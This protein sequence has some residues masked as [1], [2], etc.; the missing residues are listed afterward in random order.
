MSR[1]ALIVF[2]GCDSS[3]KT[4]QCQKLVTALNSE[5]IAAKL[6]AFPDRTTSTGQIINK[7]LK[8]E[9]DLED[10]AIHL[11][12]TANRWQVV[13]NMIQLLQRGTTLIVDRYSYSG[14][15]YSAAKQGIDINWCKQSEIGLPKPDVVFLLTNPHTGFYLKH[16]IERYEHYEFQQKVS[17]NFDFLREN[18][19][20]I[21]DV[22]K[23][24]DRLHM[25]IKHLAK[26]IIYSLHDKPIDQLWMHTKVKTRDHSTQ[27]N[28][29]DQ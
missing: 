25:E 20:I 12:F 3:G 22:N 23:S 24:I 6:I 8:N 27:T 26:K 15:A 7:Y 4:T 2:E 17:S 11:L 28:L 1:G 14:V 13:P 19:W 21:I 29:L 18:Y 16:D 5:G 9:C 10:H